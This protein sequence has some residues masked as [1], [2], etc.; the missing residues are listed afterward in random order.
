MIASSTIL[1]SIGMPKADD[2]GETRTDPD[3]ST[4]EDQVPFTLTL[5]NPRL[6]DNWL[7]VDLLSL[8]R[9]A[10]DNANTA[11]R[12]M[13]TDAGNDDPNQIARL[14]DRVSRGV[15]LLINSAS[16]ALA[17]HSVVA[18]A[19]E[20]RIVKGFGIVLAATPNA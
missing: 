16:N 13:I 9:T 15:D 3:T 7:T 12:I 10:H 8:A 18:R 5:T 6:R 20:K 2:R 1:T 14:K 11:K 19:T 17:L 4:Y